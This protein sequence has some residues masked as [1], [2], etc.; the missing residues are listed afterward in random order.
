MFAVSRMGSNITK[1]AETVL[2]A[3]KQLKGYLQRTKEEGLKY[4]EEKDRPIVV[5][6]YSD[7]SFAPIGEESHGAFVIKFNDSPIFWR[8]GRQSV[9][10]LSTAEAELNEIV[11]AM[12]AAESISV[13]V[14]EIY[15]EVEKIAWSDSQAAVSIMTSE[16]GSWRTRHLRMKAAYARQAIAQGLWA[17]NHMAGDSLIADV[18]TKAVSAHRLEMLKEL[19][20]MGKSSRVDIKS[21]EALGRGDLGEP[22]A[23]RA[24]DAETGGGDPI[25]LPAG[26]DGDLTQFPSQARCLERDSSQKREV[27]INAIRLVILMATLTKAKG[28]EEDDQDEEGE[29]SREFHMLVIAYTCLVGL[30]TVFIQY[31][32]NLGY[33]VQP[34][35]NEEA[36]SEKTEEE[37]AQ[38]EDEQEKQVSRPSHLPSSPKSAPLPSRASDGEVGLGGGDPVRLPSKDLS[39]PGGRVIPSSEVG[40]GGGD[41]VRLLL[42]GPQ[43]AGPSQPAEAARAPSSSSSDLTSSSSSSHQN[44]AAAQPQESSV[45]QEDLRNAMASIEEEER[46]LRNQWRNQEIP[47]EEEDQTAETSLG[48]EVLTTRYGRVYH[49]DPMCPHL[50][51]IRIGPNRPSLWCGICRRVHLPTRGRPPPG[52]IL[53]ID[54]WGTP[55]HTDS[56]C[57][58]RRTYREVP[59]CRTCFGG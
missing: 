17:L 3:S 31:L 18:G 26:Q 4:E 32:W 49:V 48:F 59:A 1:A 58:R 41:P 10:T 16:G 5:N 46:Q 21:G 7:A 29:G 15:E 39:S 23:G 14:D 35:Q 11:E 38:K 51:G 22:P 6:A 52:C 30:V 57:S 47:R 36:A 24:G 53:Y 40:L 37:K 44:P 55:V 45:T 8:S 43:R 20:G 12:A 50:N 27:A 54:D 25:Q 9:I 42:E 19:M 33:Q 13:I 2:D 34:V 56:R 28:Q